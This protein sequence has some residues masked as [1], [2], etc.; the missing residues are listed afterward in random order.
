MCFQNRQFE[1]ERERGGGIKK[2]EKYK[3]WESECPAGS[4]RR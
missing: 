4:N 3:T 2:E 1:R